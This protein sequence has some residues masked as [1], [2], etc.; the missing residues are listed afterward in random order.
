[1]KKIALVFPRMDSG[2]STSPSLSTSEH[3]GLGYI[4]AVLR[5][6]KHEVLIIN[7][8][9]ENLHNNEVIDRLE[10]YNPFLIGLSPVS[11]S[12][13]NTLY[14][15]EHIKKRVDNNIKTLLGGHLV[16]M[17]GIDILNNEPSIDYILK[18]DAEQSIVELINSILN[19]GKIEDV[20]GLLF[21]DESFQ[22]RENI[23]KNKYI[24]LNDIPPCERDDLIYLSK[25]NSFDYTARIIAS[26]GCFYNCSFCTT[27]SFYGK[28][29]RFRSASEVVNEMI[30]LQENFQI[31][32]FWF[33]D[34]LFI[35]GTKE[36]TEW[37]K[38]FTEIL[39]K[40]KNK[41]SFRILC[42]ADSFRPNNLYLL[43]L[44]ITTGLTHIF[45]GIESGSQN[46]LNIYNKKITVE[47]NEKAVKLLKEKKIELQI[48]F[49]MY[50]P[51][52]TINDILECTDFLYKIDE[53]YRIFPLTRALSVF[54]N[55]PIAI[56]LKHDNLMLSNS[57][58]EPLTCYKYKDKKVELVANRMSNFYNNNYKIDNQINKIIKGVNTS[59]INDIINLKKNL[60]DL[61]SQKMNT[62]CNHIKKESSPDESYDKYFFND[63]AEKTKSIVLNFNNEQ[64]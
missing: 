10:K 39:L 64:L 17:C 5:A 47:K 59:K 48:G 33:N 56:K 8:E 2:D 61:N 46:S 57:Y 51:Y 25:Q 49:I 28:V 11:L 18:G 29:V 12:I 21:R 20:S 62:Y 45:F 22:I 44:L 37:V 40:C 4:A 3:L 52:S 42:R 55:T 30:Y 32:H 14:I 26:R 31:K 27:P 34:D 19:Q 16:T 38:E 24:D 35:N 43:D 23:I 41:F 1:M 58:K 7:A 53:I 54:P 63:W 9:I 13:N 36:N 15:T 6:E 60:S 50:N